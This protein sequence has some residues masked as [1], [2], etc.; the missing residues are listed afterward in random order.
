MAEFGY[1]ADFLWKFPGDP[2]KAEECGGLVKLLQCFEDQCEIA[3]KPRLEPRPCRVIG[4]LGKVEEMKP[5]LKIEGQDPY[6]RRSVR[7]TV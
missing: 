7:P 6:V 3:L 1:F 2:S 4:S 5:V